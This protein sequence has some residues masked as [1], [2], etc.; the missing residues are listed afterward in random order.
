MPGLK[1]TPLFPLYEKHKARVVEFAGWEMPV[2]FTGIKHEHLAV[3]RR[4]G[5]FDVSHMGEISVRGPGAG[6]FLQRALSSD[7][8]RVK[9]GRAQYG[10]ILNR[11]GGIIDDVFIYRLGDEEYL[12]CVNASNADRDF[13]WLSALDRPRCELENQSNAWAQVAIQGPK[14]AGIM[15]RA[16]QADVKSISRLGIE[17]ILVSGTEILAARTGYTG[18][19]GFELFIP[20]ERAVEV[21]E[22]LVEAGDEDL[23]PCG[24]G[25]RDTLRL[26]MGYPLHGHDISSETT[27]IEA[28]LEWIT[29]MEKEDFVGRDALE[30]QMADGVETKRVGMVMEDSGVPRDGYRIIAPH[31]EGR[32]TSGTKTPCLA[33]AVA[34]GYV[35]VE[36]AKDGTGLMIEIRSKQRKAIVQKWPFYGKGIS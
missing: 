12:L 5:I 16:S 11:A 15:E 23:A 24:L 9:K 30:K 3:R 17:P 31:G 26:E 19:D 2:T 6:S 34:M 20:A 28:D 36:D 10:A 35:P 22:A 1:R 4:A 25:A 8:S 27:P 33:A 7:V 32:V 13:Q 14:A 21:W 18:E 29:A